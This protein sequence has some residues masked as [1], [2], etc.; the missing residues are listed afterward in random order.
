[1]KKRIRVV[2]SP[3]A[4]ATYVMLQEHAPSSKTARSILRAIEKKVELIKTDCHYGQPVAKRL[5]PDSYRKKY[6]ITN[7]FRVEL[8][9]FWRM[10]YTLTNSSTQIEIIAFVLDVIAHDK[11]NKKFRYR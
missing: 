11:Y 7:L 5:I 10:L 8:P 9:C 4:E 6:G 3:E 1:M 2:F